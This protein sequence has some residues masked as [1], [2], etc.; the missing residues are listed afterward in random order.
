M[1]ISDFSV[2]RQKKPSEEEDDKTDNK[3]SVKLFQAN[4]HAQSL[5]S[6][7]WDSKKILLITP[8]KS[9]KHPAA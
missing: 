4:L 3:Q 6:F 2:L 5:A 9:Y 7:H 8:R 1:G